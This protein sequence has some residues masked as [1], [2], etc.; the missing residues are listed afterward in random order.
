[1]SAG[2]DVE[3]LRVTRGSRRVLEVERL[4]VE[5]GRLLVVHGDASSGKTSL[6]SALAGVL[7]HDGTVSVAGRPVAGSPSWRRRAGLAVAVRDGQ[8]LAGCSVEEALRLAAPRSVRAA[9]ALE[10]FPQLAKRR[11]V[12]AQALSGGE[13]QMLELACAWCARPAVLV[14]DTP[15]AGL[16]GETAGVV[17]E[18]AA[19]EAARGCAVLWL[20]ADPRAAPGA[21]EMRLLRGR[22]EPVAVSPRAPG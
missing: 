22:L 5:A 15:T 6:A 4:S 7:D 13:Q 20:E 1:M 10:R 19:A 3:G 21:A 16:A 11:R 8:R 2:L 12:P 18:L 14:L 9:E 17:R